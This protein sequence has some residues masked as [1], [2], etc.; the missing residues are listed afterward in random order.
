[1]NTSKEHPLPYDIEVASPSVQKHYLE[2]RRDGVGEKFAEMCALQSPPSTSGTDRT[3]MEGRCNSQQLDSMPKDHALRMIDQAKA[4][5][6][7]PSGKYYC[8][9]IAD[10]RGA[11]DPEAW[12]DSVGDVQRVAAKRNM[13]IKGAVR[14][15]GRAVPRPESKPLSEKLTREMMKVEGNRHPTM[16]KGELR[17]MVVDKYGR[18]KKK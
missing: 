5:G 7:N 12:V 15:K 1:M 17:E 11:S 2:M 16:N 4:A 9:G 6:V 14:H 18:K 3:F 13:T 8:S 10:K